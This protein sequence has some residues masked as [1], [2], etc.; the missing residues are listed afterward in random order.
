VIRG[1]ALALAVAS[2]RGG[3]PIVVVSKN[4]SEQVLLSEILAQHLERRGISVERRLNLGGTYLCDRALRTGQADLYVEYTGTALTAILKRK[5]QNG[6]A[7]ALRQVRADY[8]RAGLVW[9]EPLGFENTFAIL[10][11]GED[12][13][14]LGLK[15][16]SDL[17]PHSRTMKAGFGYEFLNR[18]DGY[19]GLA[20]AYGLALA[21][22]RVM[23]LGLTYRA[24]HDGQ[25][26]VIAGNSTDGVIARLGLVQLD[27]DRRY[28]PPYQAAPVVRRAA[29]QREA[30]LLAALQAL[31]GTIDAPAMRRMNEE[32]DGLKR[33]VAD[34]A[35]DFLAALARRARR[36]H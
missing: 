32:V 17:A 14:R 21:E 12:S 29:L 24:L 9:T 31:G 7:D 8:A 27:D 3:H 1:L 13:R 25:V 28:F 18:Q 2:C 20:R 4:F 22:T 19:P 11:R 23:D 35:R 36:G 30:R 34:V 16:I 10:V 15:T 6:P 5:A 33:P 26:D